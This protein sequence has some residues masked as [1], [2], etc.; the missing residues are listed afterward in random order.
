[1]ISAIEEKILGFDTKNDFFEK[2]S[3]PIVFTNGCFDIIHKGHVRLLE[4]AKREG[5]TLVVGL[6]SD[7]SVK[8]LKGNNRPINLWQD[9]A[10]ILA[11]MQFVDYIIGFENETPLE[12]IR[13]VK[14]DVLVKGG[15][16]TEENVVGRNVVLEKGGKVV[17]FPTITGYSTTSIL[18]Q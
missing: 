1:M 2:L 10:L 4:F 8:K 7:A 15:D 17:I 13:I 6:N 3:G 11:A 9:R 16:Y 12:L 14:P 18:N 5:G